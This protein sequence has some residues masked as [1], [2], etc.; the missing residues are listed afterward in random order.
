[1][2]IIKY[3]SLHMIFLVINLTICAQNTK[4]HS[5]GFQLNPYLNHDLFNGGSIQIVFASRYNHT[6]KT[7]ITL[8][9]ELSGYY[10][11]VLS[12]NNSLNV[13][14]INFG[15]FARYSLHN[16]TRISLFFE[17]SP[18]ITWHNYKNRMSSSGN[19]ESSTGHDIFFSGYL[20]PGVSLFSKTR[21]LSLDLF[22]KFSDKEFLNAKKS[23]FSYRINFRF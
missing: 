2:K 16:K 19:G 7:N 18:Y 3:C 23:I 6:I 21:N 22:F 4:N 20:A 1:M 15:G 12:N 14:N 11:R 8:G 17:A 13:T 10:S 9:P 5:L